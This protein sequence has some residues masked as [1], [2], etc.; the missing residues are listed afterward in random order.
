[1]VTF[2]QSLHQVLSQLD[3]IGEG[4]V[5]TADLRQVIVDRSIPDLKESDLDLLVGH[6]DTRKRGYVV[7]SNFVAKL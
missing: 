2:A 4:L 5:D 3:H 6:C 7:T 1:L